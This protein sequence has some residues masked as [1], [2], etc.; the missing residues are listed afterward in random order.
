[1]LLWVEKNMTTMNKLMHC[2]K[3]YRSMADWLKEL[4]HIMMKDGAD[5]KHISKCLSLCLDHTNDVES[6]IQ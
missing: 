5:Y 3:L 6:I 4:W 1:M 2:Y